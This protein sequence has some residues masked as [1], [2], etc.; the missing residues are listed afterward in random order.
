MKHPHLLRATAVAAAL[1][2][3]AGSAMAYVHGPGSSTHTLRAEAV[4]ND[5]VSLIVAGDP[6]GLPPDSPSL[7]IDPNLA[8]SPWSGVLSLNIR[9]STG[10]V[11][12]A[13]SFICSG[14][15]VSPIHIV[16]AA[17][18]IDTG[19][20]NGT[21]TPIVIGDRLAGIAG[22]GDVRAVYNTQLV[23]GG[24][25]SFTL[26]SAVS[27]TMH[28]NYN[29]FGVCPA[30]VTN[31]SEFCINDD[32]AV[33]TLGTPAP[34]AFRTYRVDA[35]FP[36]M[37]TEV[38]HVGFGT[39]GNGVT[40]HTAGSSSFFIKRTGRGHIDRP[41]DELDDELNFS[42]TN[43][44]WVAD[45]DSAALG[46][47]R[48]CTDFGV[49]S[50]ILAND[51]ETNLGGGDS[52]GP[53]FVAGAGGEWLLVGNNTF[54][55]RFFDGQISGTFGTAYGGMI[56]GGYV[57]FLQA[58][59]GGAVAVVPEPGTYGMMALGLLAVGTLVRRRQA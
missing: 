36:A 30:A 32:I 50:P 39:T 21:G 45:F 19:P 37:G 56:L 44:I 24:T 57:D 41:L 46:I 48:H 38:T 33:I 59:T 9:Y 31:P 22:V 18:C 55:R 4:L 26:G 3:G 54:G 6:G 29:G 16:T 8:S 11:G 14:A 58:A 52:G 42:G 23:A 5:A 10:T 28:P 13:S 7:R 17:H 40:G 27:V 49:C 1:A 53:S 12:A 34:A 2:A 43:E 25:N 47:D 51:V 35:S 15:L 20:G